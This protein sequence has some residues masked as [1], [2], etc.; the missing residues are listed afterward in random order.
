MPSS[1]IHFECQPGFALIG[2][3]IIIC[4]MDKSWSDRRPTTSA[5]FDSNFSVRNKEHERPKELGASEGLS[6]KVN[7][8]KFV[9]IDFTFRNFRPGIWCSEPQAPVQGFVM[10]TGRQYGD[11][12]RYACSTGYKLVGSTESSCQADGAW[13]NGMPQCEGNVI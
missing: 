9:K 13:S 2:S 12:V 11:R 3:A 6:V 10:G 8:I 7:T 4:L 1:T 5:N